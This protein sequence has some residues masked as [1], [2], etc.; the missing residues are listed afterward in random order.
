MTD[1]V[2]RPLLILDLDEA[3]IYGSEVE[4]H[5]QA[6]F[7]VGPFHI[8]ERP[9]LSAFLD[10]V[11]IHYDMA[12][13]SSA[14]PDYVEAIARQLACDEVDWRFVWS[15]TRCI[16]RLH[17]VRLED[18]FIKDLKKVKRLGCDLERTLIVDDTR[19]KVARNYGNAIYVRPFEGSDN[20]DDLLRLRD[21]LIALRNEPNFR[22]I[23]KR[24]WRTLGRN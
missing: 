8:Y 13:W 16:Q 4:L 2:K 22:T 23:E 10:A 11:S 6:D 21:Y 14:S 7:R 9:Y 1:F 5:R 24:G 19:H 15:R 12:V 18:H 20:D 17:P 3:L